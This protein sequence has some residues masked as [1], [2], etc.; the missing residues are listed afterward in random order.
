MAFDLST[1]QRSTQLPPRIVLYGVPGIGKTTLAAAARSPVFL[2]VED[3]LGQLEVDA[4]PRPTTFADCIDAVSSLI[5]QDHDFKTLVIDSLDK[6]EP[7]LW[8]H[9]I[10]TVPHEKGAKVERIEQYGYGKG[11]THALSEW[12]SLLRGLD[13]L[14]EGKGMSI[15]LIAHSAVV[16]FETPDSDPYDRYQLRLHKS[17]DACVSDWCDAMLFANYKIAVVDKAGSD[18]KRAVGKGERLLYTQER[19][20]F[21]A[22]NRYSMPETLPMEW[23][24]LEQFLYPAKPA[25]KTKKKAAAAAE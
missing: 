18:R 19:P 7:L 5:E 6:L 12:R 17:A 22:K 16:K 21:R 3:G 2:P 11:Y 4:F 1:V 14:R 23:S 9:V 10:E 24:E 8:D 25:G 15:V 20:S 13:V